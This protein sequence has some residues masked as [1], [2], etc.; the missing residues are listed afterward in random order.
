MPSPY[1]AKAVNKTIKNI[2]RD[3]GV[4]ATVGVSNIIAGSLITGV[5]SHYAGNR[6]MQDFIKQIV[7]RTTSNQ[8]ALIAGEALDR[9]DIKGIGGH[10]KN[11]PND[12]RQG[13]KGQQKP[14]QQN[15]KYIPY[16]NQQRNYSESDFSIFDK[17]VRW[18]KTLLK[19]YPKDEVAEAVISESAKILDENG[20]DPYPTILAIMNDRKK[21]DFAELVTTTKYLNN[22]ELKVFNKLVKNF[23]SLSSVQK[24]EFRSSLLLDYSEENVDSFIDFLLNYENLP[25]DESKQ[26]MNW[27]QYLGMFFVGYFLGTIVKKSKDK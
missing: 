18:L 16:N 27:F 10:G 24:E 11:K 25:S 19:I 1:L 20:Y 6:E 8:A 13:Q 4:T 5:F 23:R 21:G 22:K 2:V 17:T 15:Q 12:N 3:L 9:K 26:K 7:G 14:Y